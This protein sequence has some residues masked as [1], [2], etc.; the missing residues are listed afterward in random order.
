[1]VV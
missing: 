1:L